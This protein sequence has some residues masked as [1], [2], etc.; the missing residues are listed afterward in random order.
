MNVVLWVIQVVLALLAG[1][2]GAYKVFM[3]DEMAKVPAVGALSK[4]GWAAVGVLEMVCAVLL[5]VPAATKW[6]P[7][8]TPMAAG[9]L[10]LES[11]ALAVLYGRYSLELRGTNP[12]VY[13]LV[14]GM[15]AAFVAYGR[16]SLKPIV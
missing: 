15:M 12:L 8:L 9:V 16:H 3:F 10:A 11:L 7:E 6:K 13:V 5:I 1:S 14:M 2:G 4:S